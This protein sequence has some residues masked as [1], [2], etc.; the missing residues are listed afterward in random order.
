MCEMKKE[1]S[2]E[3]TETEAL[4]PVET[5]TVNGAEPAPEFE[6]I[7]KKTKIDWIDDKVL[8]KKA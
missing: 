6:E 2:S 7:K 8:E 3:K 5:K 1:N 4:K